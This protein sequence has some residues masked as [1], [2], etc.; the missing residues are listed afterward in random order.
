M[1]ILP[2]ARDLR[3]MLLGGASTSVKLEL[4]HATSG[5]CADMVAGDNYH[6][7]L[8]RGGSGLCVAQRDYGNLRPDMQ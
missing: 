5:D 7:V 2:Q 1:W 3:E 4:L 6:V 8:A